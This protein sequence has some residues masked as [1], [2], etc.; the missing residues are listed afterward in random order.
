MLP[1]NDNGAIIGAVV[2][3]V[4]GAAIGICSYR[5]QQRSVGEILQQI[6]EVTTDCK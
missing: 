3:G 5:R 1:V 4:I 2:G 6:E